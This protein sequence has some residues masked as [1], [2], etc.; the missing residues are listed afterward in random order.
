MFASYATILAVLL[1]PDDTYLVHHTGSTLLQMQ[2]YVQW[3]LLSGL[4][5]A[6]VYVCVSVYHTVCTRV[7]TSSGSTTLRDHPDTIL[8]RAMKTRANFVV[9]ETRSRWADRQAHQHQ[10]DPIPNTRYHLFVASLLP[11]QTCHL[12][13]TQD[14]WRTRLVV[15]LWCGCGWC[16]VC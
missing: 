9:G 5:P 10:Y 16:C 6:A 3:L 2:G 15:L 13:A 11:L 7:L 1:A 14:L 12:E 4:L 8:A